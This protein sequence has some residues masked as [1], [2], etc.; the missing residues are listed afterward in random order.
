MSFSTK[1]TTLLMAAA[2]ATAIASAE[3]YKVIAPANPQHEGALA[4]LTNF[5]T[6]A[7]IDSIVVKDQVAVFTGD[8]DEPVLARIT[9]PS[10]RTP[11]FVLEPGTISF[12]KGTGEAFGSMLNDQLRQANEQ[13]QGFVTAFQ[14]T[15]DEA[16]QQQIYAA[17]GAA[18][19]SL[20]TANSDNA[21]G[22]YFFLNNDVSQLSADELKAELE[23][24]P[25]FKNYA[26]IQ[27]YLDS[28]LKREATQPGNKF[29]DFEVTYNGETN[30]LSDHVGK[31]HYT[32]VD[33]WAS[34]CGPCMRQLPV[35]KEIYNEYKDQGL[36]VLGVA[37]WDEP[38]ATKEAIVKHELPWKTFIDAQ[39]IPTDLYGITGIPCIILFG[40]DGT[41][42]SR[43]K[44]GD[45]LKADVAAAMAKK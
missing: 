10:Y 40:P 7:V 23:K 1:V 15:N 41:I 29:V 28:A 38:E 27:R 39:T 11:V 24:Y 44:Q 22:Y 4:R 36:E 43:D 6:G 30:R 5:D 26:R 12:T 20:V 35:L 25:S 37:V 19:D 18:M 31:G 9:L 17:Y 13:L 3:P 42:I 34:W 14:S 33:F 2:A 8:I 16:A 45:E 21:L 32:L